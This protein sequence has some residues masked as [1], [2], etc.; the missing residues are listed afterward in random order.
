MPE[1]TP[2]QEI[3]E[4]RTSIDALVELL[5]AKGKSEL[6]SLAISLGADP[7]IVER[8]A[9]VLESGGMARISYEVGRMYLEPIAIGKEEAQAV[10]AKVGAKESILEQSVNVQRAELDKFEEHI[11]SLSSSVVNIE[12]VYRQRMPEVQQMLAEIN[13]AYA[14]VESEQKGILAI[15]SSTESTYE[16]I[17]KHIDE[18]LSKMNMIGAT[19]TEKSAAASMDRVNDMLKRASAATSEVE[20]LRKTKDR[21][22]ESLKKTIDAQVKAFNRQLDATNREI[23]SR[24]KVGTQQI[25]ETVR[26]VREQAGTA[27]D[28]NGQIRE[29]K[30]S[31]ESTKRMLNSAR[32]EFSDRYQKLN[33]SIYRNSKLVESNSKVLTDKLNALKTAFGEATK[34]DDMVRGLRSDVNDVS[35]QIAEAKV[36][37]N[38]LSGALKTLESGTSRSV[39]Q[40]TNLVDQL[41]EKDRN[42]KG[43]VARISKKIEDADRKAGAMNNK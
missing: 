40:R 42:T 43:K 36:E 4:A 27:K 8:W 21:F 25:Q 12:S 37:V 33:E 7:K 31:S 14:L 1:A 35:K 2:A 10:K 11:N 22:F 6:N 39:E 19:N 41:A 3:G 9:K 38:D 32:I 13:R 23:E 5:G 30:R 28:L 24:L 18:L 34:L 16:G 15:K 17:N 29:F 26:S 20:E